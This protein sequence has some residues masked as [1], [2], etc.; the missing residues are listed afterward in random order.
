MPRTAECRSPSRSP[1]RS[2]SSK[3]AP[4][5]DHLVAVEPDPE[6]IKDW[7]KAKGTKRSRKIGQIPDLLGARPG[8]RGGEGA[9]S[10]PLVRRRLG[11]QRRSADPGRLRGRRVSSSAPRTWPRPSPAVRISTPSPRRSG[12]YVDAGFT[13]IAVV[14]VGDEGQS[15]FLEQAAGPLLSKLRAL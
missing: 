11:G 7:D 13:D 10:V 9:R 15:E 1:A 3:F 5:A 2:R 8:C 12:K 14:Q 6:L 4:L